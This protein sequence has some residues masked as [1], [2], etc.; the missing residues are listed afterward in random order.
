MKRGLIALCVSVLMAG[1]VTAAPRI[2]LV[3]NGCNDTLRVFGIKFTDDNASAEFDA[4]YLTLKLSSNAGGAC[5][6]YTFLDG[7]AIG[8]SGGIIYEAGDGYTTPEGMFWKA[9]SIYVAK[10][11]TTDLFCWEASTN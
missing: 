3:D 4:A 9:D 10:S 1:F 11:D 7:N 2:V 8:N 6:V 5:T